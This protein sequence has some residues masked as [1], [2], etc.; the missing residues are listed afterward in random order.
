M[1]SPGAARPGATRLASAPSSGRRA[2]GEWGV[3]VGAGGLVANEVQQFG[4]VLR[5]WLH[6][7]FAGVRSSLLRSGRVLRFFLSDLGVVDAWA[8]CPRTSRSLGV[9]H[10][11]LEPRVQ[12]S[13]WPLAGCSDAS[14][15]RCTHLLFCLDLAVLPSIRPLGLTWRRCSAGTPVLQGLQIMCVLGR[16][17]F[18]RLEGGGFPGGGQEQA[19]LS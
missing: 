19:K 1:W 3:V 2:P 13:V 16:I 5:A 7:I 8:G 9:A 4:L 11:S 18:L 12:A 17:S 6:F 15:C 14:E 10:S